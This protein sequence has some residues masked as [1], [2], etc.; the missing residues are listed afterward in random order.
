M[1]NDEQKED[2]KTIFDWLSILG[3]VFTFIGILSLIV[4]NLI[5]SEVEFNV[6]LISNIWCLGLILLGFISITGGAIVYT[7][8]LLFY[9]IDKELR[10]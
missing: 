2:I 8:N 3:I 4:S 7:I 1:V 6:F 10:K 9:K 5:S